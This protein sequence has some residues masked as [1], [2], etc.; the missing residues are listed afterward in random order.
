M[1]D[2]IQLQKRGVDMSL[3]FDTLQYA[4]EA[5]AVGFTQQQAE[6]Q[7][8]KMAQFIGDTLVTKD[9]FKSE[10]INLEK[11]LKHEIAILDKNIK[12]D[13]TA[14]MHKMTWMIMTGMPV[15]LSLLGFVFKMAGKI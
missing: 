14:L 8:E 6:F 11:S 3:L 4:K 5:V 1:D 7:A 12:N 9:Y 15:I 2:I 10:L 13:T